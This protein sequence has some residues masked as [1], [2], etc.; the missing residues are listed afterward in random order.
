MANDF[1]DL[2]GFCVLQVKLLDLMDAAGHLGL[3]WGRNSCVSIQ[4]ASCSTEFIRD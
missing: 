2:M 1:F 3:R 4:V